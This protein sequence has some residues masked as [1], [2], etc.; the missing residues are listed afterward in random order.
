FQNSE[1]V[2]EEL[3][4]KVLAQVNIFQDALTTVEA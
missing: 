4:N 3:K 2:N 1:I